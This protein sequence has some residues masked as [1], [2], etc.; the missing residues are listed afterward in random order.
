MGEPVFFYY[1]YDRDSPTPF[2][3]FR[4]GRWD[5]IGRMVH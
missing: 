3:F 4:E 1:S 2:A 5:R